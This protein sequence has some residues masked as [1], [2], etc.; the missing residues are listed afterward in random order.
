MW[1]EGF[2]GADLAPSMLLR[3]CR[4]FAV[5]DVSMLLVAESWRSG[6]ARWAPEVAT[7]ELGAAASPSDAASGA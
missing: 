5:A 7:A 6:A 4:T 2:A 1:E 3:N